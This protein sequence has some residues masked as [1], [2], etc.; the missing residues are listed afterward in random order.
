MITRLLV[1][2]VAVA[3]LA[4]PAFAA[5]QLPDNFY[6]CLLTSDATPIGDFVIA[7]DEYRGPALDEAGLNDT[8]SFVVLDGG[9]IE[10][11]GALPAFDA[12]GY[13]IDSTTIV[14]ANGAAG[15]KLVLLTPDQSG[16]VEADCFPQA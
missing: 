15:L 4:A 5:D 13:R 1:A 14:E 11:L 8:K 9:K 12:A 16:F 7:G 3:F 6:H 10:W 2:T